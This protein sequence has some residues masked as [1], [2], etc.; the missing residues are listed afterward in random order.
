MTTSITTGFNILKKH[1]TFPFKTQ[2]HRGLILKLLLKETLHPKPRSFREKEAF[3]QFYRI[4]PIQ[5]FPNLQ[6]EQTFK[7][8]LARRSAT[9]WLLDSELF[10]DSRRENIP[11]IF[12]P[13]SHT[14]PLA[15]EKSP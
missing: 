13:A 9:F 14:K 10:P 8:L 1:T 15:E 7:F 2:L 11:R 6:T 5:T 12:A 3:D 4:I